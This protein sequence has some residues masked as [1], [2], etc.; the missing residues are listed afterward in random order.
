MITKSNE[1]HGHVFPR[2]D[3]YRARCGGPMLC[4]QCRID[5]AKQ[6][7]RVT[8]GS[9]AIAEAITACMEEIARRDFPDTVKEEH[10]LF[11]ALM[12]VMIDNSKRAESLEMAKTR[13]PEVFAK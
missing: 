2:E 1:G 7:G 5:K 3:G 6:E 10:G 11:R 4:S 9:L 13:F 12:S 8:E